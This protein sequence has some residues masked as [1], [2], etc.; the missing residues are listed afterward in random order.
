MPAPRR[1]P[2]INRGSWTRAAR[3]RDAKAQR[4]RWAANRRVSVPRDKLAFPQSM[5]AKLRFCKHE[6][7]VVTTAANTTHRTYRAND[8]YDPVYAIGGQQPRGFDQFMSVYETFTV[9]GAKISVNL[10]Y[11]GYDGPSTISGFGLGKKTETDDDIVPAQMPVICGVQK[12]TED[13]VAA[14]PALQCEKD[15][16]RWTIMTPQEGGKILSSKLKTSDFFGKAALVGS[17]GY[18]GDKA[19]SPDQELF[20][21]VWVGSGNSQYAAAGVTCYVEAIVTIEYDAV[22]TE[23]LVLPQS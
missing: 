12:S 11:Q 5:S 3:R 7:F 19:S 17:A 9:T 21:H 18:T 22:F 10:M 1:P 16:T 15:R 6:T 8:L 20:F 14:L 2:G 23:P 4:G 13:L